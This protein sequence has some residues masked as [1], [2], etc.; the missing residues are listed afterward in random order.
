MVHGRAPRPLRRACYGRPMSRLPRWSLAP[1]LALALGCAGVKATSGG[2]GNG[3]T[4]G[5][6][7]GAGTGGAAT[8]GAATG[9]AAGGGVAASGGAGSG[10]DAAAPSADAAG[11]CAH[12]I[13]IAV[14]DFRGSEQDGQPKHPDFEQA[15]TDDRGFVAAMLGA[16]S[17]P[18]YA[19]GPNGTPTTTGQA[20]FDQWYRDVDGVNIHVDVSIPL[21]EDPARPGVF[22]YDNDQFFPIDKQG[23]PDPY[24]DHNHDFTAE[25]HFAF[26][27]RGGE[28]FTFR[29]DDD[30]FVFINGHL[31]IDLGGI[32][33][34]ETGTVNLDAR[35]A[36]LGIAPGNTYQ[37]DIFYADRHC[38]DS[39]F[40][41]ET[42][43][44]CITNIVVSQAEAPRG[45]RAGL[46][47]RQSPAAASAWRAACRKRPFG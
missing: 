4:G 17:K 15:V 16:D 46:P 19:G 3:A 44:Q 20:D 26:P 2:T 14:R 13:Q 23:W 11:D 5:A 29:G 42:T 24:A 45:P 8:G 1:A 36:E 25:M 31:V 41:I 43:L 39:T 38:C 28:A 30:V 33:I 32:H 7:S 22:V 9:G 34:A 40:H 21:T 37:M 27:Y 6:T 35:A 12:E 18:V 10:H 47:A